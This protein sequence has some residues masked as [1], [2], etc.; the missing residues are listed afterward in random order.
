M[1]SIKYFQR[2]ASLLSRILWRWLPSR[3][4]VWNDAK[5]L[6]VLEVI[7]ANSD[8]SVKVAV[9]QLYSALALCGNG[10]ERLL[11]N[12]ENFIKMVV[13][14]M[15]STQP[16][17][18]RIEAFKLAQLLKMSEQRCSKMLRFCCEPIVQAIIGALREFNLLFEDITQDTISMAVEAGC[19]ALITHWAGKHH[20]YFWKLEI[21]EVLFDFCSIEFL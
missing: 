2:I 20:I 11:E 19:L 6:R 5:L 4:R 18:V 8:S 14:W 17:F 16:P 21:G 1:E 12:G 9:L 7:R 13:H 15:D 10:A 3:Y